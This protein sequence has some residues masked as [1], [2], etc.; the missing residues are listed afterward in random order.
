MI[1]RMLATVDFTEKEKKNSVN[2]SECLVTF[3]DNDQKK[4]VQRNSID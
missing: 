2:R 3:N 1:E 4:K